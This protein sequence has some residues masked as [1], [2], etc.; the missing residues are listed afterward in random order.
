MSIKQKIL[1][2]VK[3]DKDKIMSNIII[4]YFCSSEQSLNTYIAYTI[5]RVRYMS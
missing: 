1:I 5:R 3:N 2:N 4:N